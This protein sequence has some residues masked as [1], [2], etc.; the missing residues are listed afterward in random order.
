MK[1]E[2]II[3]R[4]IGELVIENTRL[5]LLNAALQA[6]VQKLKASEPE[7]PLTNKEDSHVRANAH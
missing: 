7:L 6:E 4:Q 3:A 1:I 5:K 2:D